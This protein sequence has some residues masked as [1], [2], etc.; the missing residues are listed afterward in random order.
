M[1]PLPSGARSTPPRD[2]WHSR[3]AFLEHDLDAVDAAVAL[4]E[5]LV[6]TV[7]IVSGCNEETCPSV[8]GPIRCLVHNRPVGYSSQ[9]A[10][11]KGS[12][13]LAGISDPVIDALIGK[14]IAAEAAL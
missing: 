13:N 9:T 1:E 4:I 10:A 12:Q 2:Q 3:V 7:S 6:S 8:T 14:I 5:P 11:L